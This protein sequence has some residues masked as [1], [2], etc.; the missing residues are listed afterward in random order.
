M[1]CGQFTFYKLADTRKDGTDSVSVVFISTYEPST[2][3][4][5]S[6]SSFSLRQATVPP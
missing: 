4:K 1:V 2:G 6:T 3:S 5:S